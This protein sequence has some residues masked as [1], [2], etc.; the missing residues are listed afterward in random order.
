MVGRPPGFEGDAL[1]VKR[2]VALEGERISTGH[3]ALIVPRGHCWLVGDGIRSADSRTWGAVPLTALVGV[4]V[5][6]L[7][8]PAIASKHSDDRSPS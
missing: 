8:I 4:A 7:A 5:R 2:L 6:R 1:F 3:G